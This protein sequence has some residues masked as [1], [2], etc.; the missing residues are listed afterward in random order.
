MGGSGDILSFVRRG[1]KPRSFLLRSTRRRSAALPRHGSCTSLRAAGLRAEYKAPL[2]AGGGLPGCHAL[3]EPGVGLLFDGTGFGLRKTR[4]D[5]GC[6]NLAGG[7]AT[8]AR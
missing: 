4:C 2:V 6:E 7:V 1:L 3:L 8:G 5:C